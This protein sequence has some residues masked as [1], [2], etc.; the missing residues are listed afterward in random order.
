MGSSSR[1]VKGVHPLWGHTAKMGLDQDFGVPAAFPFLLGDWWDRKSWGKGG[2]VLGVGCACS[3]E[4]GGEDPEV[5]LLP[6]LRFRVITGQT[7]S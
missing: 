3:G 4:K 5:S 6:L 7:T 2:A 1:P